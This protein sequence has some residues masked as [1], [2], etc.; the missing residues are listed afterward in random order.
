MSKII[1]TVVNSLQDLL[2][3]AVKIFPAIITALIIIMLT[4]YA[5]Q[6]ATKIALQ[7]GEKTLQSKSLQ[8]L[9]HCCSKVTIL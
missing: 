3:S 1:D 9:L 4:R 7:V 8:L 5:A 6:F 2:G